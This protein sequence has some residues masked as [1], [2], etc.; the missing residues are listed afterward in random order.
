M[1]SGDE[2]DDETMF[3]DTV[4]YPLIGGG[5]PAG[6]G[7]TNLYRVYPNLNFN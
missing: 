7:L 6:L 2:Y 1:S 5:L 3:T 4:R